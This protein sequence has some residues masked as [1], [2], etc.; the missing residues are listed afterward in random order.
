VRKGERLSSLVSRAGGFTAN[1]YLKAAQF[2]RAST[3]KAQQEAIDKLIEDL[4]LEVAQKAQAGAV[5]DKED[6]EANKELLSARRSL[7]A[8]LRKAKAKGRVVIRL[9]SS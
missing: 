6:I 2:T 4:E 7:I 1:A 8:Q 3:Q 9:M 5:L